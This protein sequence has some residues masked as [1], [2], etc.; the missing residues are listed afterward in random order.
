M[1]SFTSFLFLLLFLNINSVNAQNSLTL[2]Q[3]EFVEILKIVI[4]NKKVNSYLEKN[5]FIWKKNGH[6]VFILNHNTPFKGKYFTVN[7][8]NK[9]LHLAS[10]E[11][12]FFYSIDKYIEIKNYNITQEKAIINLSFINIAKNIFYNKEFHLMRK[13]KWRLI[14]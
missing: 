12:M 3:E 7:Y 11:D 14:N 2:E 5:D 9:I 1:K 13:K 10:N 8:G 6:N 4:K